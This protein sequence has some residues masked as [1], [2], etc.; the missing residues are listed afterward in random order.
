[1]P[2]ITPFLWFDHQAEEA[3][4]FYCSVFPN[5]RLLEVTRSRD[6]VLVVSFELD[7]T[8]FVALNGGPAHA[9]TEA[10]SF[11]VDCDDQ[12]Q[13]DRYW[14]RLGQGGTY[15]ACG[16]LKD[17]Y[18]LSWQIVPTRLPELL[19]DP[20]CEKAARVMDAMMQMRRIEIA[21]LEQAAA[22]RPA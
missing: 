19:K 5:S 16:W 12:E 7:G 13:V 14:E 18:A 17:R 3:A 15:D 9:F 22:A 1:M 10:V 8:R 21:G 2:E 4:A 11:V 20:D 6:A